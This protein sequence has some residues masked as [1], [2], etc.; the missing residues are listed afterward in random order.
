MGARHEKPAPSCQGQCE[1][2][3]AG[4]DEGDEKRAEGASC[5]AACPKDSTKAEA[6]GITSHSAKATLGIM[7]PNHVFA[8]IALI[9]LIAIGCS[10]AAKCDK[11]ENNFNKNVCYMNV[12]SEKNSAD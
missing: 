7:K 3:R 2:S 10:I 8:I 9:S 4:R 11:I 1:K 6:A 5:K 12:A